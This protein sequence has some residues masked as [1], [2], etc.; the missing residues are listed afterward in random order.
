MGEIS[1]MIPT[2]GGQYHWI[3]ILAPEPCK[4]FL[5]YITGKFQAS[6]HL[7]F[8]YM[9]RLDYCHRLGSW[10]DRNRFLRELTL[11]SSHSPQ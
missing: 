1:S 4:R 9:A 2:A 8:S 10:N 6:A 7:K 5:S 3:S 11:A